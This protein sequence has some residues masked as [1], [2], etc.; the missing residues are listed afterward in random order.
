MPSQRQNP[1]GFPIYQDQSATPARP[2]PHANQN[3][4]F[5]L[6]QMAGNGQQPER[7]S[8]PSSMPFP[9]QYWMQSNTQPNDPRT[10][11]ALFSN[12]Q[13]L[14]RAQGIQYLP[15]GQPI[16][17]AQQPQ[18]YEVTGE[19]HYGYLEEVWRRQQQRA[20]PDI[21]PM[22][23]TRVFE[24]SDASYRANNYA[25]PGTTWPTPAVGMAS[26]LQQFRAIEGSGVHYWQVLPNGYVQFM[27]YGTQ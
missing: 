4:P 2:P 14:A 24:A 16:Q 1:Q 19:W 10:R 26:N 17:V 21:S 3:N 7:I 25:V 13:E 18:G 22:W 9:V 11:G 15:Q 20:N 5:V 23:S 8:H 12:P 27:W 6:R